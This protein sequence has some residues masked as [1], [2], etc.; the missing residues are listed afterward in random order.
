MINSVNNMSFKAIY[1]K[2]DI[3]NFSNSQ[4]RLANDIEKKLAIKAERNDYLIDRKGDKKVILSQLFGTKINPKNNEELEYAKAITVGKYDIQHPFNIKDSDAVIPKYRN[5][6]ALT[7]LTAVL[8]MLGA[9]VASA[10]IMVNSNKNISKTQIEKMV[11]VAKD[12]IQ[13][14]K[15]SLKLFK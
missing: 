7:Y 3:S 9:F 15:D 1:Y 13:A 4:K 11:T 5:K 2:S 12:S 14:P 8:A 10:L 6:I